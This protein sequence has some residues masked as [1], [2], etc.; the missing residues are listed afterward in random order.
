[1]CTFKSC[2]LHLPKTC[3]HWLNFSLFLA[4]RSTSH[5]WRSLRGTVPCCTAPASAASCCQQCV[6]NVS[7]PSLRMCLSSLLCVVVDWLLCCVLSHFKVSLICLCSS[8]LLVMFSVLHVVCSA[9]IMA[10]IDEEISRHLARQRSESV[11][12]VRRYWVLSFFCC[13]PWL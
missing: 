5:H 10:G 4:A 6:R 3:H 9:F 7:F 13:S 12:E 2:R 11:S 1:M 8:L